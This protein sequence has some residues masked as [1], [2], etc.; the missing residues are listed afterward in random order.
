MQTLIKSF[1]PSLFY[2][3][4]DSID[5]PEIVHEKYVNISFP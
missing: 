5:I 1:N 2:M 4:F 3:N